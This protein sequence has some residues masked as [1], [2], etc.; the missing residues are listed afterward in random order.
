MA[1]SS[2]AIMAPDLAGTMAS[3][4][5]GS[6]E[7]VDVTAFPGDDG[8][9]T[10][11]RNNDTDNDGLLDSAEIFSITKEYGKRER[12]SPT[13][14]EFYFS[15]I[16]GGKARNA[17]VLVGFSSDTDLQINL[18]QV[19][20]AGILVVEDVEPEVEEPEGGLPG[21]IFYKS[22]DI[23]RNTTIFSGEWKLTLDVEPINSDDEVTVLLQ[24][25]KAE[26]MLGLDPTNPDWDKDGLLDGYELDASFS[27]W[28][29]NPRV[30]DSDGDFWSDRDEIYK[31]STNPLSVDTDG[32][33]V[34]DPYD[35]DPLCNLMIKIK[36]IQ[37][38]FHKAK[39]TRRLAVVIKVEDQA[40]ATPA[41]KATSDGVYRGWWIFRRWVERTATFNYEYY[42][43]IPDQRT[44]IQIGVELWKITW[45]WDT[46][47]L[48][49]TYTYSVGTGDDPNPIVDETVSDGDGDWVSFNISTLG[50]K[51]V[52]TLAVYSEGNFFNGHYPTLERFT[53]II[54]GINETQGPFKEGVNVIL[55]PVSVFI[56][57]QLHVMLESDDPGYKPHELGNESASGREA[58][59]HG[60][61]PDAETVSPYVEGLI[62]KGLENGDYVTAEEALAILNYVLKN[63]TGAI[64][65]SYFVCNESGE[66]ERLGLA[67]DILD[68]IPFDAQA[69][70]NDDTGPM[71]KGF[72]DWLIGVFVAIILFIVLA[73]LLPFILLGLLIAALVYLGITL[74]G[75][76][77]AAIVLAILKVIILVY[78]FIMLAIMLLFTII[79]FLTTLV[80]LFIMT[81]DQ[82]EVLSY[83]FL[84]YELSYPAGS[85]RFEIAVVFEYSTFLDLKIPCL[86]IATYIDSQLMFAF[87]DSFG[88]PI[89]AELIS[90]PLIPEGYEP[91]SLE[92]SGMTSS[93]ASE[94][95]LQSFGTGSS[96]DVG[97]FHTGEWIALGIVTALMILVVLL[98]QN[99]YSA[100]A[101]F[102]VCIVS[103]SI[104]WSIIFFPPAIP[105]ET[106]RGLLAGFG[107]GL[108]IGGL[109]FL[110]PPIP[111]GTWSDFFLG[112]GVAFGLYYLIFSLLV[113]P[114]YIKFEIPTSPEEIFLALATIAEVGLCA[115]L[116][117]TRVEKTFRDPIWKLVG[118]M[119]LTFGLAVIL[120]V[121]ILFTS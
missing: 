18:V 109:G 62:I 12:F 72:W 1:L 71:P 87:I 100:I 105:Y 14:H 93:E 20:V 85:G 39:W 101:A 108:F 43:D 29:T 117:N 113:F 57:T 35:R 115:K 107:T 3:S 50:M 32:D 78:V 9:R 116:Y 121:K 83:G 31:Y 23:S 16:I 15:A 41:R 17:T 19:A 48:D 25:F 60:L 112:L 118:I 63:E 46:E 65:F 11:L 90:M 69:M 102:L 81:S 26:V 74:L 111:G 99:P 79:A 58:D 75:S 84:W 4:S 44:T 36:V 38:H 97:A 59:F 91:P 103:L 6:A 110:I 80:F 68:Q 70:E 86:K 33:G 89:D 95:P 51:R 66:V 22:Y 24:D 67:K 13:H 106:K 34:N 92:N 77:F 96:A 49:K 21:T 98:P 53:M 114:E 56:H 27:G 82:P 5:E 37:G 8:Y 61:D 7:G 120:Q 28:L 73:V 40:V 10:D 55:V 119:I 42:F 76:I 2:E 47:L 104:A 88:I 64:T 45:L 30:W 52:N 54:L 94:N